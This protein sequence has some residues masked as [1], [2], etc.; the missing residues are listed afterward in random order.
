MPANLPPEYFDAEQ[1]YR[2]AKSPSEKTLCIEEMLRIIPKHKGTDK[3]RGGLR[4]RLSKLKT[5]AQAKKGISKR[6][7]AFRI[8]KEGAGQIV[9]VGP[10]NVGKSSLVSSLTNA[11]P[12]ISDFPIPPGHPHRA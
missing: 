12:E 3:I 9:L 1:R 4:K 10:A 5:T 7:S 11:E 2:A 6:E 8:D